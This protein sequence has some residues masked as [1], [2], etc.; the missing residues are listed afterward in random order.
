M[1]RVRDA[2]RREAEEY[3]A[4]RFRKGRKKRRGQEITAK[5]L[6]SLWDHFKK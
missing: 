4:K 5:M 2:T 3:S 6:K 1:E